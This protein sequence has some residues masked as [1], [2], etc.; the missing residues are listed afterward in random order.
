MF[1]MRISART[2]LVFIALATT[3]IAHSEDNDAKIRSDLEAVAHKR[4]LFGHQS[5]GLNL[6][7]GIQQLSTKVGVP[8]NITEVKSASEV[9]PAMFG[10]TFIAENEKPFMK[11]DSLEKAMG[12]QPTNLDI[13]ITKFCFVDFTPQTDAKALFA[14]YQSTIKDLEA[15]NPGT[16]FVHVTAP[17]T[18]EKTG[19][20][21]FVK[22]LLGRGGTATNA[23]REEYNA[24]LRKTYQGREPVFDLAHVE[25]TAPDGKPVMV[26][27][28]NIMVP[29][30][31]PE[32]TDDGGHLN[33]VGKLRAA[34]EFISV[35]A[36]IP[37]RPESNKKTHK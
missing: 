7:E 29:S 1:G 10:H 19:L 24:L 16:T 37:G 6:I 25:S 30:M 26:E 8:V 3:P 27:W 28:N 11:L 2:F 22:R 14:R 18:S 33:S 12:A 36:S 35:L 15:K 20:K 9:K 13:T 34:R 32:Y 23:R 17:L 5:V 4:I 31:D 21:E